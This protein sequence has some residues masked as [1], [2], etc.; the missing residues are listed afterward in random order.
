[1]KG[2][3]WR[4]SQP[5]LHTRTGAFGSE[6]GAAHVLHIGRAGSVCLP[7]QRQLTLLEAPTNE[8]AWQRPVADAES[9]H[10]QQPEKEHPVLSVHVPWE[11]TQTGAPP[12]AL[13][14]E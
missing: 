3:V 11:A 1:M 12:T 8:G 7:V 4:H 5:L 13:A 14:H 10:T 2:G 9:V 6:A